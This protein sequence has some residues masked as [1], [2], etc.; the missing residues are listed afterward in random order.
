MVGGDV[1]KLIN[2]RV[3]RMLDHVFE[4]VVVIRRFKNVNGLTNA[5]GDGVRHGGPILDVMFELYVF[6]EQAVQS[7]HFR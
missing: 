6:E 5:F 1:K 3:N 4:L 7:T 2:E